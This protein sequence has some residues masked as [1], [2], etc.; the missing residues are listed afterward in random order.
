MTLFLTWYYTTSISMPTKVAPYRLL[1]VQQRL[2]HVAVRGTP[3]SKVLTPVT[4][5]RVL[6][7]V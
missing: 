5:K 2:H 3:V 7:C 6:I 4:F 1:R